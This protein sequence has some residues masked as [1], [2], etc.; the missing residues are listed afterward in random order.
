MKKLIVACFLTCMLT[1]CS[2]F[3]AAKQPDKKN[4]NLFKL[5]T[6]RVQLLAEFGHPLAQDTDAK[7]RT[8]EV[9]AFVQGYAVASKVG[10]A[11]LHGVADVFTLGLWEV[12]GTPTEAAFSGDRVAYQ[13]CYDKSNKVNEVMLLTEYNG[14]GLFEM[15]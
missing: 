9:F 15:R 12:V 3:M 6:P 8:C 10:R 4:V 11:A 1:G 7:G 13:V 2:V 14:K 5:G